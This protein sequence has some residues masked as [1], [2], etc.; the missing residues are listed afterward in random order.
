MTGECVALG[1]ASAPAIRYG[2]GD[3]SDGGTSSSGPP[4]CSLG[5]IGLELDFFIV[6]IS[7][8]RGG[9][10][11]C[12]V[13]VDNKDYNAWRISHSTAFS[14]V[15]V[16]STHAEETC[17]VTAEQYNQP[18]TFRHQRDRNSAKSQKTKVRRAMVRTGAM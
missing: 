10:S 7:S 14:F 11:F 1:I 15:C 16:K 2:S 8:G 3:R 18:V 4:S 6:L 9:S 12:E 13:A 17:S 5:R